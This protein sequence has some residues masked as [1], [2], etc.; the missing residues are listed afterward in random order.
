M[1]PVP[2]IKSSFGRNFILVLAIVLLALAAYLIRGLFGPLIIAAL[3]AYLLKP[4]VSLLSPRLKLTQQTIATLVYILFASALIIT[5][6]LLAPVIIR[7]AQ[8]LTSAVQEFITRF[9]TSLAEPIVIAGVPI[10]LDGVY[11]D[12]RKSSG[13]LFSLD[14]IFTVIKGATTNIA[15]ILVIFVTSF[16]LLRD[17]ENLRDWIYGLAPKRFRSD[18][19][20][21]HS[22]I[23]QIWRGYLRGQM[24]LMLIIGLLST[25]CAAAIGLPDAILI[26]LIAGG[27]DFIPTLGPVVAAAIAALIAWTKGSLFL[28]ISPLWFTVVVVLIFQVIQLIESVWLPPRILGH[29]MHLHRGVVF[30]AVIS[31]LTLGSILLAFIIVPLI[32]SLG[33]IGR[34][35]HRGILGVE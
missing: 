26:G 23:K 5:V 1:G 18:V 22:E 31:A 30:V 10:Q 21:I 29:R 11:T 28:P 7:Q 24:L 25:I 14:R 3:I 13:Q 35:I 17:W 34:Y 27:L 4:M 8:S 9:E 12:L 19:I 15:W 6:L 32:A 2:S 20:Q 16:H 33:V